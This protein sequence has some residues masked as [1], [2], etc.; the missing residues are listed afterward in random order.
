[1]RHELKPIL[2]RL[3]VMAL[4][5]LLPLLHFEQQPWPP[6]QI[7]ELSPAA[8]A[9]DAE[10]E[11]RPSL[12]VAAMPERLKQPV[13]KDL[14][15]ALLIALEG[16]GIIDEL[17]D[18]LGRGGHRPLSLKAL[19]TDRSSFH[20]IGCH[21]KQFVILKAIPRRQSRACPH[22]PHGRQWPALAS[23]Q[24]IIYV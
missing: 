17:A 12:L 10:F 9:L 5:L 24:R 20:Q 15:L 23:I 21:I 13:A 8:H 3:R 7:G 14:G 19:R 4:K 1:M 11:R 16:P 6:E 18:R 22:I 2:E